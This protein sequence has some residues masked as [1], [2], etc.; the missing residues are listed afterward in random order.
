[1]LN[2]IPQPLRLWL[3]RV[4][5]QPVL[6]LACTLF[7]F[8]KT[9]FDLDAKTLWW[10]ESLSLQRSEQGWSDLLLGKLV[11]K[12][13]VSER[14]TWDQ[15]PFGFY[16]LLGVLI[17]LA[18]DSI[19]VLRI[20][21]VCAATLLVPVV[22]G[23]G[24]YLERTGLA[25]ERTREWAAILV[26]LN[27]LILWYGQEARPYTLWMLLSLLSLWTLAEW[28]ATWKWER[29]RFTH[30][31]RW[32][33]AWVL[34]TLAALATHFYALL[35][36]PVQ[37]V[38]IFV[39]L[40]RIDRKL[41]V[42]ALAF[43][44][45]LTVAV[46]VAV[47]QMI[48]GQPGAGSNYAPIGLHRILLEAIH[49][50]GTGIS[51]PVAWTIPVD[52]ALLA[53]AITGAWT[54]CST[55]ENRARHGWLL[56]AAVLAPV[57]LLYVASLIQ[58]N[59]MAVRHHAQLVGPYLLLAAAGLAAWPRRLPLAAV[60][61]AVLVVAGTG[62]GSWR[63]YREPIYGKAPDYA[64]VGSILEDGLRE[65]DIVLF[66]GPNS[67]RLFRRFF[68]M[69]EIETARDGDVSI[70]WRAV[71]PLQVQGMGWATPVGDRLRDIMKGYERV[72]LVEDRTLPYEDPEHE[73]LSWMRAEMH[74]QGE[75]GFYHPNS[76]LTLF[77]FL[78]EDPN[79]VVTLPPD[80][81]AVNAVFNGELRLRHIQIEPRLWAD[82][83][84][85]LTLY[86]EYLQ[87]PDRPWRFIVWLEE[88]TMDGRW[89][90]LPHSEMQGTFSLDPS[91]AG[92]VELAYS[93]VEAP[94]EI[95]E[96]SSFRLQV[97]LYDTETLDKTPVTEAGPWDTKPDEPALM[98]P[99]AIPRVSAD[100]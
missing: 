100:G 77:L 87:V 85:P 9:V 8:G 60:A 27:P 97:L 70:Q 74:T 4:P 71:P 53:A 66:K 51:V 76:S 68:P 11:L 40:L 80:G 26:A 63:Y 34:V 67:W 47:F 48:T 59:Y 31:G 30:G 7:V 39:G 3:R 29:R 62:L 28:T 41:A 73:V 23:F 33:A 52:V 6:V 38:L 10:D 89:L 95:A 46:A 99:I 82:G 1:M 81:V 69:D 55:E 16:A 79:P 61:V 45:V 20:V 58:P 25:P 65:G 32:A 15:H 75:W 42:E 96:G 18:G 49:G 13:G 44:G 98:I 84:V 36:V 37:A 92:M 2:A 12:D 21:S 93:H 54:M 72:W 57:L 5:W 35:L 43:M 22:W 86:W 83:Q 19:L 50:F 17:R 90:K 91:Q 78:P 56:S 88:H 64:L 94:P 14:T 24:G